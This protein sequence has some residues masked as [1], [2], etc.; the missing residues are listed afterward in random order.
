MLF[1]PV[2]IAL[3]MFWFAPVPRERAP[4]GAILLAAA[5]ASVPLLPIA[6]KYRQVHVALGLQRQYWEILFFSPDLTGFLDASPLLTLWH[7]TKFHK[8]EGELF[9]GLTAAALMAIPIAGWVWRALRESRSSKASAILLAI[10]LAFFGAA[11]SRL[12]FGPWAIAPLGLKLVSV[13]VI[14]KP[15]SLGLVFLVVA[16]LVDPR[17]RAA[18]RRGSFLLFY[19][20]A[21]VLLFLLALG[22]EPRIFG[23]ALLYRTAPYLWLMSIPAFDTAR[24]PSRFVMVAL[25]ALSAAAGLAFARLTARRTRA[26]RAAFAVLVCAAVIAEGWV[27]QMP[28]KPLP[29]RVASLE[30]LQ[31][32]T[33]VMELP[34]PD[35]FHDT[36]AMYRSMYHRHPLVNGYSGFAP[37]HF[38][39]FQDGIQSGDPGAIDAIAAAT[40]LT[41]VL[42]TKLDDGMWTRLLVTDTGRTAIGNEGAFR[43]FSIPRRGRPSPEHGPAVPVASVTTSV[44]ARDAR[45][46]LDGD[47]A[48]RWSTIAPQAG[49]EMLT[50]DLGVGRTVDGVSIALGPDFLDYPRELTVEASADASIWS[51]VW[52]GRGIEIAVDAAE[53]DPNQMPLTMTFPPTSA[54]WIRM[55]EG[56]VHR[57]R[58]WSIAEL[59]VFGR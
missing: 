10:A 45:F 25:V 12:L 19:S 34:M 33:I 26:M 32:D 9:P 15:L 28:L 40:P 44:N 7:L 58:A 41:V 52:R 17:V 37:K 5:I 57:V 43:L 22:P 42:D 47:L 11:V 27:G 20:V 13:D 21:T 36:A 59:H 50:I 35:I 56:T 1:F 30:S 18:F 38:D 23:Q 53:R 16:I 4:F 48:T 49:R 24:V 6:W 54:R 2:L 55:R 3:W 39:I 46:M 31:A 29:P 14:M 51:S 8:P